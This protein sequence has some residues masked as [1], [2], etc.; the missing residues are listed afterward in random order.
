[1]FPIWQ[2]LESEDATATWRDR[3]THSQD[4]AFAA[5]VT[6][7]PAWPTLAAR[8]HTIEAAGGDPEAALNAAIAARPVTDAADLAA[9][10]H[11]RLGPQASS[12][13]ADPG[14]HLPF[15]LR[16]SGDSPYLPAMRQVAIRIDQRVSQLG[17]RAAQ[18]PPEWAARLG[19]VPTDTVGRAE[20]TDRAAIVASYREAFSLEGSDPIGPA[21]PPARPE[22]CRWW[23]AAQAALTGHQLLAGWASDEDPAQR[24]AAGDRAEMDRP[25]LVDLAGAARSERDLQSELVYATE[26]QWRARADPT[27]TAEDVA[28]ARQR[29]HTTHDVLQEAREHLRASEAGH[30]AYQ[31]WE[32]GT[33]TT[34]ADA[35]A[36]RR[37]L[38]RR[39][40]PVNSE[41]GLAPQ[42]TS[43]TAYQSVQADRY[44]ATKGRALD[45][46][47]E[48]VRRLTHRIHRDTQAG[49][50][51][52]ADRLHDALQRNQADVARLEHEDQAAA[53]DAAKYND[54][55]AARA[56]GQQAKIDAFP[57]PW[58]AENIPGHKGS[59]APATGAR[60]P[61][62][63]AAT[64]ALSH[65]LS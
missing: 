3:I 62:T 33:G 14:L 23:T 29:V 10:L 15:S 56:D 60:P 11:H 57:A 35:E 24:V 44:L 9:V 51:S 17:E 25:V 21:P 59:A 53:E 7:V 65:L 2:D 48:A 47:R 4:G 6:T 55:L 38:V 12:G 8:L 18:N 45:S 32:M 42:P 61:A 27:I 30:Q 13:E 63:L 31:Q 34:R 58:R 37:E 26:D 64:H 28:A 19:P 52:Q 20:W 49:E 41:P 46:A 5:R 16:P 22:A 40:P 50:T 54:E 39:N 1:M 43:S 36:A